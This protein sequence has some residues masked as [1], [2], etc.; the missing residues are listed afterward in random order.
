VARNQGFTDSFDNPAAG[1]LPK[2]SPRPN[3]YTLGYDS[4]EYRVQKV[5]PQYNQ[6]AIA[7]IPGEYSDVALATG[8]RFVGDLDRRFASLACRIQNGSSG[9]YAMLFNAA[10]RMVRLYRYDAGSAAGV[11][12]SEWTRP[13]D[14]R[15][16]TDSNRLELRCNGSDIGGYVN[17]QLVVSARDQTFA[18]G[19]LW[20]SVGT[21]AGSPNTAEARFDNLVVTPTQT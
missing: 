18:N 15:P 13:P 16:A 3:D 21:F 9:R 17:D 2:T 11:P 14:V 12:L 7:P 8:V 5:N 10:T 1:R 6:S 19:R 20:L 4:G